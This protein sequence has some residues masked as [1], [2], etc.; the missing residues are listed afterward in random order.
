MQLNQRRLRGKIIGRYVNELRHSSFFNVEFRRTLKECLK[1]LG[2][3]KIVQVICYGLGSFSNGVDVASRYQLA[4]LL[5]IYEY[6]S[7]HEGPLH[8]L[9]EIFDPSFEQLDKDTLLL[10][11]NPGF[12]LIENN[13]YC[14]RRFNSIGDINS[15]VLIYMPHLDKYLYNNLMGANWHVGS[16][17][18]LLILGNSFHEMVDHEP[19]NRCKQQLPYM[20]TL[21]HSFSD[22][23]RQPNRRQKEK[24]SS[25]TFHSKESANAL[26]ELTVD[27]GAFK[28]SDVFNN[29]AFHLIDTSWIANNSMR[30]QQSRI[31][32]WTYST[33]WP[34]SE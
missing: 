2:D 19:T 4:L 8:P 6:L 11:S 12:K 7:E 21:V 26:V 10:F 28:H 33:S 32:N 22:D 16:L 1:K 13:E 15:C 20:Y 17:T 25:S 24:G 14:A 23:I 3:R 30:V 5:L 29:L 31:A 18:K 9:I 27:D 34:S